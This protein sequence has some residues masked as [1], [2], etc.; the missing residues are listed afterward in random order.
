V[1][2]GMFDDAIE[3]EALAAGAS[4]FLHKLATAHDLVDVIKRAWAELN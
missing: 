3:G 2:T 1:I 4:A